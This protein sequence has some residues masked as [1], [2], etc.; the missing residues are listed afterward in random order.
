MTIPDRRTLLP[1]RAVLARFGICARSLDRWIANQS[2]GFPRPL[3]INGRRYFCLNE[4][5]TWERAQAA[6]NS[7]RTA[8]AAA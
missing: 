5:E 7:A 2:L 3:M 6:K 4:L 1:S 8:E